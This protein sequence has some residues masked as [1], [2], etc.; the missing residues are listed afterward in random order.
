MC[1]D[2]MTKLVLHCRTLHFPPVL[3]MVHRSGYDK[4][5]KSLYGLQSNIDLALDQLSETFTF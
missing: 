1:L 4:Y 5:L 2:L 3:F